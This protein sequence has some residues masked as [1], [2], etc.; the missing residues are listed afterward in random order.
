MAAELEKAPAQAPAVTAPAPTPAKRKIE[1]KGR[2]KAAVLLVSLGP[3]RAAE[4]F[5]HLRDEEIETL[6]LEMA[7]L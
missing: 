1:L 4:V 5:K 6:S 7:G 3:D 2:K